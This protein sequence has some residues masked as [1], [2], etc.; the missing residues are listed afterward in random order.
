MSEARP[1]E[2]SLSTSARPPFPLETAAGMN[3]A[4]WQAQQ[5]AQTL[6]D[7]LA[8]LLALAL[9]QLDAARN[10]QAEQ[11]LDAQRRA[12]GLVKQALQATRHAVELLQPEPVHDLATTLSKQVRQLSQQSGLPI[13]FSCALALP[14]M[15]EPIGAGLLAAARELLVNA[16]KHG[17]GVAIHAAL[18]RH[19]DGVALTVRDQGLG[20]D[21]DLAPAAAAAEGRGFGL[22]RLRA[23]LKLL[24]LSLDLQTAPGQG[25]HAQVMWPRQD[26]LQDCA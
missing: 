5:L 19:G 26:L 25:V 23:R 18:A 12:Y 14:H 2:L 24:G 11:A 13:H 15:P 3:A 4:C 8:Q 16:C 17:G 22:P 10:S 20:F 1:A 6:H 21:P 7:E 9:M